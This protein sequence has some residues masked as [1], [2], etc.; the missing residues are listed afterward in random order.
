ME[1][2]LRVGGILATVIGV[3]MLVI[4][5]ISAI[6]KAISRR[7][8]ARDARDDHDD[9]GV[10]AELAQLRDRVQ[11]LEERE[12]RV[13]ELEERLDFAERIIARSDE[14]QLHG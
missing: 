12:V 3:P 9:D 8:D 7:L 11:Q 5:F 2:M 14:R 6:N 13:A 4:T 1:D 10:A